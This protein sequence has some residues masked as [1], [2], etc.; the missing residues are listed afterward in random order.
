MSHLLKADMVAPASTKTAAAWRAGAAAEGAAAGPAAVEA[1]DAMPPW[2]AL[3]LKRGPLPKYCSQG[4][5]D[6]GQDS[7]RGLEA[8]LRGSRGGVEPTLRMSL[9]S[10]ED[11]ILG[12]NA[13]VERVSEAQ[14]EWETGGDAGHRGWAPTTPLAGK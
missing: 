2:A 4:E 8:S 3:V 6:R 10:D 13:N 12:P 9:A 11:A 5:W 7:G 1:A 14:R